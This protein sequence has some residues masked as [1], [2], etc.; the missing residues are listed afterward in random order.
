[1]DVGKD[2]YKRQDC[3]EYLSSVKSSKI[4]VFH[5]KE[6]FDNT[7]IAMQMEETGWYVVNVI[8]G[9]VLSQIA[10]NNSMDVITLLLI[11][12]VLVPCVFFLLNRTMKRP[13]WR[14]VNVL[15][16]VQQGDFSS[17]IQDQGCDEFAVIAQSIDTMSGKLETMIEQ[18]KRCLLYTSIP[19]PSYD[20]D[21]FPG[22]PPFS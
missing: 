16:R 11:M 13:L 6:M 5:P 19:L 2:V 7:L 20:W 18:V 21:G 3:M 1:M 9:G 4:E 8:D 22:L 15:N 17:R 12:I 10:L 14:I